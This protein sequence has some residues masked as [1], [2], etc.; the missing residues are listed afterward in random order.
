MILIQISTLPCHL[1]AFIHALPPLLSSQSRTTDVFET[2]IK[3]IDLL[4]P[5]AQGGKAAM[6]DGAAVGETVL[7]MELIRAMV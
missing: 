7:A 4:T 6:F 2:G 3:V 5:M 1:D